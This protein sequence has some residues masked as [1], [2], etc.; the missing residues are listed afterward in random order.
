M[1]ERH[2]AK[3]DT[4]VQFRSLAPYKN[5]RKRMFLF[6]CFLCQQ[7]DQLYFCVIEAGSIRLYTEN[8]KRKPAQAG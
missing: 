2:L 6:F 7:A 1:V 4:A 8:V 5:I 3:V